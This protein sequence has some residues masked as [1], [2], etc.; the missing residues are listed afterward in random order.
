MQRKFGIEI[1]FIRSHR[2][3]TR[4]E[5][6]NAL[7]N[8]GINTRAEGYNHTAQNYWKLITDSSADYELVSPVLSGGLGI[9]EMKKALDALDELGCKVDRRCGIHIHLDANDLNTEQIRAFCA[10]W[11]IAQAGI[12]DRLVPPSRRDDNN[13]FCRNIPT[14][15]QEYFNCN[16]IGELSY[17]V[18]SSRYRKLNLQSYFRY[19]T[20]EIRHHGGS[21][22]S[23]KVEGWLR[24]QNV[25]LEYSLSHTSIEDA[26]RF[27]CLSNREKLNNIV[28]FNRQNNFRSP[29][30][31]PTNIQLKALKQLVYRLTGCRNTRELKK[32]YA[33]NL[34]L[35]KKSSWIQI[36]NRFSNIQS[37]DLDAWIVTRNSQLATTIV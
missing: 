31:T 6:A 27:N 17:L 18:S 16:S 10:H 37:F 36:Y 28:A 1:E 5:I 35:R 29:T 15:Y 11:A 7:R 8:A 21:L 33:T 12:F 26:N 9:E 30:E 22:N 4:E 14:D 24:L 34:D 19:G 3:Q 25:F 13:H 2:N 23:Y 20:I 32:R